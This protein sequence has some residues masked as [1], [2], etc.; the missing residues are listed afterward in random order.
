M[1]VIV[2]EDDRVLRQVQVILDPDAPRERCD[3]F[4]DFVAHDLPDF[5][6]WRAQLRRRLPQLFPSTV[7]LV[8]D[9]ATLHAALPGA[10]AAIVES[11]PIGERELA[12]A[13]GLAVVQ[14]FG[15][16]TQAIDLAA[17]AARGIPVRTLRRRTN[18]S[19]AEHTL[20]F[21]LMLSRRLPLIDGRVTPQR[22]ERAGFAV[23][24]YD[25]RHTAAANFGRIPGLR[26]LH[27][28][29][30]CLAGFG[31][32]GR[33]V[34]VLAR[35]FG[36]DVLYHARHPLGTADEAAW[37]ARWCDADTLFERA[38]ILSVHLPFTEA[39]R[40]WV[41]RARIA[42][43]PRGS[44]LVN[45]ARAAIVERQALIDA[46]DSGHLAGAALD[47]LYSEPDTEDDPLLDR[48]DVV[49]TPHMAGAS[50]MNGLDDA[51][52]MLLGIQ[53]ALTLRG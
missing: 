47:V 13:P 32:I 41:D 49:L 23:R 46:L 16:V 14:K 34:G 10:D 6:G 2:V 43:M 45:T 25:T 36:M 18:L 50:R 48:P 15:T 37:G 53:D 22:L 29:T 51:R 42:R 40:G 21:M 26:T 7:R 5:F 38:D 31:E 17:C 1:P 33:E 52:D 3:A 35:A 19:L 27:G 12:L 11:L 44:L 30:L 4:A 24:P 39:T 8:A 28:R 9:E 20:M